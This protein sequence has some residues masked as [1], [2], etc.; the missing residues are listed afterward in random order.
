MLPR[1]LSSSDYLREHFFRR[2][3]SIDLAQQTTLRVVRLQRL[4]LLVI[5]GQSLSDGR[6]VV[7]VGPLD[8]LTTAD[9]ARPVLLG[10]GVDVIVASTFRAH[11][12]AEDP[13]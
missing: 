11:A 2:P 13:P 5:R 1:R 9:I 4:R 7:V 8:H 10:R 3:C 12:T 6:L